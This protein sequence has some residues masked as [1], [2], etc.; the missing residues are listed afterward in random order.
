MAWCVINSKSPGDLHKNSRSTPALLNSYKLVLRYIRHR[1]YQPPR[2]LVTGTW[3]ILDTMPHH[4]RSPDKPNCSPH[5]A[6][7][8]DL[9]TGDVDGDY[10]P[11]LGSNWDIF[12]SEHLTRQVAHWR[13]GSGA[14]WLGVSGKDVDRGIPDGRVGFDSVGTWMRPRATTSDLEESCER[15]AER[16][17]RRARWRGCPLDYLKG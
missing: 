6:N 14:S 11:K 17:W 16:A 7:D 8:R 15:W 1:S 5:V 3:A 10:S 13:V 4:R 9:I 2:H 12:R